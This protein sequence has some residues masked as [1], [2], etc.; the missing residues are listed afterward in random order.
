MSFNFE[1]IRNI[2]VVGHGGEGKTTLVEA[3]LYN[4]GAIDRL[5]KVA[6]GTTVSDYDD[7]EKA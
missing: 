1:S 6:D 7:L 2:A 4:A 3:M 5:C